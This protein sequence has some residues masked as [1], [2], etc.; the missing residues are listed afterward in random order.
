MCALYMQDTFWT[1]L[2]NDTIWTLQG[3]GIK[4]RNCPSGW[5]LYINSE[6]T[7]GGVGQRLVLLLGSTNINSK[8]MVTVTC[9]V[10]HV[11][12]YTQENREGHVNFHDVMDMVCTLVHMIIK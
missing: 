5:Q 6:G 2:L 1:L 8:N 12:Q 7:N 4:F 9:L 11:F 3:H 10:Q